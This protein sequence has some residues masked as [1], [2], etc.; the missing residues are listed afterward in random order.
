MQPNRYFAA[1]ALI[2][3]LALCATDI[4]VSA[5][6]GKGSSVNHGEKAKMSAK[7]KEN[8]NAQWSADPDHG[9][10]RAEERHELQARRKSDASSKQDRNKQKGKADKTE[11]LIKKGNY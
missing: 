5:G 3:A 6:Q 8:T 1:I 2:S 11:K 9:W 7:G 4:S 10:I